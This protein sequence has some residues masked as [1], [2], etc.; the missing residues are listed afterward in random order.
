[1]GDDKGY[2]VFV[3]W[4][5]IGRQG[6]KD[7][8]LFYAQPYPAEDKAAANA[9]FGRIRSELEQP[10][11]GGWAPP[12]AHDIEVSASGPRPKEHSPS[13]EVTQAGIAS[14]RAALARAKGPLFDEQ[15]RTKAV[16]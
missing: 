3:G 9:L 16:A 14:M 10:D 4:T 2:T 12:F 13:P 15:R 7:V 8:H 11:H 1:M 6:D 5:E